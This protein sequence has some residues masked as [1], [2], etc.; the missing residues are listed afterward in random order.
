[1]ARGEGH[2]G[3]RKTYTVLRFVLGLASVALIFVGV[4]EL[5]QSVQSASTRIRDIAT[6]SLQSESDHRVLFISSYSQ[7]HFTVPEEWQGLE[8]GFAG[9]GISFDT[10]YMDTKNHPDEASV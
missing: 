6:E 10:E 8:E 3:L 2:S 7:T 1:M 9:K 4:V 5:F